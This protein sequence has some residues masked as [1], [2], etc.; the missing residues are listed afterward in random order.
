MSELSGPAVQI[1]L[2]A[3]SHGFRTIL[4]PAVSRQDEAP[5]LMV[6][7]G[8]AA[9][10]WAGS[11]RQVHSCTLFPAAVESFASSRQGC[12]VFDCVSSGKTGPDGGPA[13]GPGAAGRGQ[14]WFCPPE[15]L[16]MSSA[17]PLVVLP[18]GSSRHRAAPLLITVF[19]APCL[20]C[21]VEAVVQ[22]ASTTPAPGAVLPPAVSRQRLLILICPVAPVAG[23][24]Q[25]CSARFTQVATSTRV[26]A[27]ELFPGSSRHRGDPVLVPPS[28]LDRPEGMAPNGV[29]VVA[30]MT[31]SKEFS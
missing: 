31:G 3:A 20:H 11:P 14:I 15:Q 28:E 21:W 13:A 1:W 30:A 10:V 18:D 25:F 24:V 29:L 2:V 5:I 12:W 27:A 26:P 22:F 9:Q 23:T 17:V 8:S 7:P 16:A 19:P 6:P 4:A